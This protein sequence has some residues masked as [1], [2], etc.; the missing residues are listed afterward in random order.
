MAGGGGGVLGVLT[1]SPSRES[2]TPTR[3]GRAPVGRVGV[4]GGQL[5]VHSLPQSHTIR[6]VAGSSRALMDDSVSSHK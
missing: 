5:T 1:Q 2:Q 4:G 3:S 6:S